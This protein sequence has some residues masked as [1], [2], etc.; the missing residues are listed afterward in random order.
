MRKSIA[1]SILNTVKNLKKSKLINGIAIK[2]IEKLCTSKIQN[3]E[4]K[5]E[6]KH[7]KILII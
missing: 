3:K 2:N 1:K 6:Q 4:T 5:N 7:Q